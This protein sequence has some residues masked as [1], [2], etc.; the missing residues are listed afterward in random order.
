[1]RAILDTHVLLWF[2]L[3]DPQLS[4]TARTIIEDPAN[5]IEI[6]P[7][8]YWE[9]VIKIRL[10]KYVLNQP[11]PFDR[12]LIAQA[13]ADQPVAGKPSCIRSNRHGSVSLL[14]LQAA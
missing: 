10:G 4:A 11:F 6:S 7:A 5:Q 13:I 8:S 1:M 12:L 2:G 3:D 9:I 14:C